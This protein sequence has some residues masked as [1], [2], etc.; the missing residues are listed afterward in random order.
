M[1]DAIYYWLVNNTNLHPRHVEYEL[2]L[3][4]NCPKCQEY[5]NHHATDF[6]SFIEYDKT[7]QGLDFWL[8]SLETTSELIDKDEIS[9]GDCSQ[10]IKEVNG[11]A[12]QTENN[13]LYL[14]YKNISVKLTNK[15]VDEINSIF[16]M[17]YKHS[18]IFEE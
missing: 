2:S 13:K 12:I 18:D 6:E 3:I 15:S 14:T 9:I 4:Y 17:L 10:I 11:L 8:E 16:D 7:P 5:I 1:N